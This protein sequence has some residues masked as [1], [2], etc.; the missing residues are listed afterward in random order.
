MHIWICSDNAT[1]Q[2]SV[3]M[4]FDCFS[5]RCC[6]K[7]QCY[8]VIVKDMMLSITDKAKLPAT[9]KI[10]TFGGWRVLISHPDYRHTWCQNCAEMHCGAFDLFGFALWILMVDQLSQ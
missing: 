3:S 8:I 9:L 4:R 10:S 2:L 5:D 7:Y 1:G 6:L